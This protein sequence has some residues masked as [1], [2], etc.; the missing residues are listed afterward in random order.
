MAE[1]VFLTEDTEPPAGWPGLG[2]G[3]RWG[4]VSCL[5]E[6]SPRSGRSMVRSGGMGTKGVKPSLSPRAG[7]WEYSPQGGEGCFLMGPW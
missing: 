4:S 1:G 2:S 3:I 5:L 7:M 6:N